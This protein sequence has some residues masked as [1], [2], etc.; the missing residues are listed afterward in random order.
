MT[1][2]SI[3]W[4]DERVELLRKLWSEGLSASQIAAELG[5]I[6]RNAVIGKVH[7]LGL[8][9]RAKAAGATTPRPRKPIR[10]PGQQSHP[11]AG[12]HTRGNTALAAQPSAEAAPL[13]VYAPAP[14]EDV[15]VPMS[16]RVTIMELRESMC[17]WPLGDPTSPDFRFCGARSIVGLPYCPHHSRIAYQP[18]ADRRRDRKRA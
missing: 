12:P 5:G 10:P 7:R 13:P 11:A 16:E 6:T 9:G 3:T 1:D 4:S 2:P 8:S 17:R 15:V 14:R 18:V